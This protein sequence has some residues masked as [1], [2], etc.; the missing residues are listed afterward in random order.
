MIPIAAD[1]GPGPRSRE[2]G[3][4]GRKAAEFSAFGP[5][6]RHQ[7]AFFREHSFLTLVRL[8]VPIFPRCSPGTNIFRGAA[9]LYNLKA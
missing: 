3:L 7:Y 2:F 5:A 6:A 1:Q 4:H 8:T 9:S